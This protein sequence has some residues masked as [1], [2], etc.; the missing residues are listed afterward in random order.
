MPVCEIA[1]LNCHGDTLNFMVS[2]ENYNTDNIINER[3]NCLPNCF[4]TTYESVLN[5]KILGRDLI[6]RKAKSLILNNDNVIS[7]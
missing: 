1:K 6:D 7:L 2:T 3:C 4:S 5:E